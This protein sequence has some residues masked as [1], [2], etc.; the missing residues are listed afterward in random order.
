MEKHNVLRSLH[1]VVILPVL[2][3]TLIGNPTTGILS[4]L[5]NVVVSSTA[6]NRPLLDENTDNQQY[7][8][9]K[10]AEKI[11]AYFRRHDLPLAG[12]GMTFVLEAEKNNIDYRLVPTIMMLESTGGKHPCPNDIHNTAGWASCRVTFD[13]YEEAIAVISKSL[14]GNEP[15]TA[16]YYDNKDLDG[17][18]KSYNSVNPKYNALAKA[19]MTKIE[20]VEVENA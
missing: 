10:K 13:S 18:L 15:K 7:E 2:I 4:K 5:P 11:D 19:V 17:I 14:G 20:N 12:Y 8:R 3:T 6:V 9:Q 1:S 16:H